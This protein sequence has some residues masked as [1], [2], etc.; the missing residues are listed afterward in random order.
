M[1]ALR[2]RIRLLIGE[3]V[4]LGP[5]KAALLDAIEATGS[6]SAAARSMGMS[7][8]RAWSLVQAMNG[9]FRAPLVDLAAGG[10]GGGGATLSDL[11]REALGRYRE[12]ETQA[13]AAVEKSL[14]AFSPLL[15]PQ[16]PET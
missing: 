15:K 1:P 11:G 7:Y 12:M 5:G 6:L 14:R 16:D 2:P 13:D 4:A 8:R 3:S 9:D 10:R